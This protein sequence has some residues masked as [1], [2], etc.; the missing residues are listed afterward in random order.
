MCQDPEKAQFYEELNEASKWQRL[1]ITTYGEFKKGSQKSKIDSRNLLQA[2]WRIQVAL[3]CKNYG[4]YNNLEIFH[5]RRGVVKME[6]RKK[7]ENL[8]WTSPTYL[9]ITNLSQNLRKKWISGYYVYPLISVKNNMMLCVLSLVIELKKVKLNWKTSYTHQQGYEY[10]IKLCKTS[11]NDC[12][13]PNNTMLDINMHI[14]SIS[15]V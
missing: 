13:I 2:L 7:T 8:L 9:I 10:G 6:T 14:H 1:P 4:H 15:L 12:Y 11:G 3:T 5:T